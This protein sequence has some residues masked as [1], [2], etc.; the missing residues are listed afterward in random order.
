MTLFTSKE[1]AEYLG[2]TEG[3]M[4]SMRTLGMGPPYRKVGRFVRYDQAE[5]DEYI[6]SFSNAAKV[7]RDNRLER[8]KKKGALAQ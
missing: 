6:A 4:R 3:S 5:L 2:A 1:A 8:R 7:R